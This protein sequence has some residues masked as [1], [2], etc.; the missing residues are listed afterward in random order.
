M[1]ISIKKG[2]LACIKTKHYVSLS[3]QVYD[4]AGIPVLTLLSKPRQ[5]ST[6]KIWYVI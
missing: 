5:N 6:F 3:K 2:L 4:I 1:H